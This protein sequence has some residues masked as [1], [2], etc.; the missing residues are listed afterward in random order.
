MLHHI[1]EDSTREELL[2][3]WQDVGDWSLVDLALERDIDPEDPTTPTK[4][5]S[6]LFRDWIAA[7]DECASA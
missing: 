1:S 4:A 5:I 2:A 6:D 3:A 7:G